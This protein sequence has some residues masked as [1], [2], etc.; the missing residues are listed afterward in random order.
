MNKIL[1][2]DLSQNSTPEEIAF[3]FFTLKENAK[4]A[5][6][7]SNNNS[8]VFNFDKDGNPI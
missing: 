5:T 3:K 7:N 8:E 2:A 6:Q 4:N 1:K